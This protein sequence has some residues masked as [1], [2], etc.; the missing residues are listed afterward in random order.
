VEA[1][2]LTLDLLAIIVLG[3]GVIKARRTGDAKALGWFSYIE[4]RVPRKK[5]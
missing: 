5:K 2:L 4:N 3:F 1:F